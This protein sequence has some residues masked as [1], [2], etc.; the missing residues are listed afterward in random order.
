MYKQSAARL[1]RLEIMQPQP[2]YF[3]K[4]LQICS[5]GLVT[6]YNLEQIYKYKQIIQIYF[7]KLK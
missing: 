1:T 6:W 4:K 5:V 7:Y 3:N 2:S